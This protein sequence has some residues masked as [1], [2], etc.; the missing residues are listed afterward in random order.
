MSGEAALELVI[1]QRL[2]AALWC[3]LR[4]DAGG[5]GRIG[6]AEGARPATLYLG[7]LVTRLESATGGPDG[8]NRELLARARE[9]QALVELFVPVAMTASSRGLWPRLTG[10][11]ADCWTASTR[12]D[13]RTKFR[14]GVQALA[15][16]SIM[17]L[18]YAR[19][20]VYP[21]AKVLYATGYGEFGY[22]PFSYTLLE[23]EGH[24]ALVDVGF[25]TR[26]RFVDGILH[27]SDITDCA[28][29]EVVLGKLGLTPNDI[30]TVIV[31]HAHFD[32]IGALSHFPNA[33]VFLQRREVERW[34][35]ALSL[36]SQF[37]SLTAALDPADV[38]YARQLERDGRLKFVDGVELEVLPGVDIRPAFETHT[39]G[40]Q[41]VVV[42]NSNDTWVVTGD[43]IYSYENVE[44]SEGKP[45]YVGI[46]L[47]N[48][49]LWNSLQIMDEMLGGT[50]LP[51]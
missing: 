3:V 1:A 19:C 21:L 37:R 22:F 42:R 43:N 40:S 31:T 50:E 27:E 48:G 17:M 36:P 16:W 35:F 29:P 32:H 12:G 6:H 13:W 44:T 39:D 49:S 45:G 25:D 20:D 15:Q 14:W 33:Q 26:S 24:I 28:D 46:G 30:D 23:G 51:R 47:S 8:L 38:L 10:V 2:R 4:M 34:E 7:S 5:S 41:Y 18:E 9:L 11:S